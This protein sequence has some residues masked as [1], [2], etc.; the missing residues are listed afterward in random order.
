[1]PG[2]AASDWSSA[3]T[4]DAVLERMDAIAA[5]H[6]AEDGVAT[7]DRMY[8]EVTRLVRDA[9]LSDR[10]GAGEFIARLDVHFANL[11]FDAYAADRRGGPVPIAWAPLFEA[12]SRPDTHPIQFALAGMNA[13]IAH[14]LSIAVV[15]TCRELGVVPDDDTPEHVD[16][17]LTNE[18]LREAA[19]QIKAWFST[20]IVATVDRLGGKVDD[21]LAMFALHTGRAAAWETAEV[22]WR[23]DDNPRVRGLFVGGLARTVA[24]TSRG[25]LL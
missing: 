11:F 9:E 24:L 8:R 23:I 12:R 21:G 16:F 19:E 7:F 4:I 17:T 3:T 6:P 15:T 10:F 18:V 13:H 20:G 25:I 14:D 5:A 22:L 1:M 2:A